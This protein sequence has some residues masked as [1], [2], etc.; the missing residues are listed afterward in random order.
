MP[1]ISIIVPVYNR[2]KLLPE[3]LESISNQTYTDWECVLV[4][5]GST[6]NSLQLLHN[7]ASKDFR[8][9]VYSRPEEYKKGAP[10]CRNYGYEL[11]TGEYIQF[12]TLMT[13]C[14]KTC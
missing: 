8:L 9:K 1:K 2:E 3:T 11:A 13:S 4:D 14:Y 7:L 6:D 5:D 12:L 10:S